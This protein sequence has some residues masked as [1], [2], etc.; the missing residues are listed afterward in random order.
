MKY[1]LRIKRKME[2]NIIAP[3]SKFFYK[4]ILYKKIK[5]L[6]KGI[7]SDKLDDAQIEKVNSVY[8]KFG[9][10][11]VSFLWHRFYTACNGV[12]SPFYIPET[13]FY[14]EI[15]PYLNNKD[16]KTVLSDK[17]LL[18]VLFPEVKQPITVVKNM[19]GLFQSG[20][21]IISCKEAIGLCI[22]T[23][24]M[25]I[26]PSVDSGGGKNIQVFN[27]LNND[28][29]YQ[30]IFDLYKN[31]FIVQKRMNQ[32]PL[33]AQLNPTSLNTFRVLSLL[34]GKEV[35]PLS[36]IVRMGRNGAITDN[37]TSGGI[38]C[39]V[40]S[41]GV[42][43]PIGFNFSGQSFYETDNG[44]HFKNVQLPFMEKIKDSVNLLHQKLPYF[45]VIS[46]DLAIDTTS[47][48]VLIE[49]N[50]DGQDINFHQWNNGPV[51]AKLLTAC[52]VDVGN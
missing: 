20:N 26:K 22:S 2:Q 3:L 14:T 36:T 34:E 24:E 29:Y 23:D 27:G 13:L 45:R 38:S 37:S 28:K 49:I 21:R 40:N 33:M 19:N 15:E 50:V 35:Q 41:D 1:L 9:V 30:K 39:G 7:H 25:I 11:N 42:L 6:N 8:R 52:Y 47:E 43:N 48:V 32:H 16:Y 10:K 31:D 44:M 17:N 4:R 51:L 46:W 12:F 5:K 18:E